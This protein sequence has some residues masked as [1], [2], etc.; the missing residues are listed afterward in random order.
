[1][2]G[3]PRIYFKD[4]REYKIRPVVI[5]GE[6]TALDIDVVI[7]PISTHD[8][9]SKYDIPIEYWKETGLKVASIVRVSKITTIHES[10]TIRKIG[11]MHPSD[12]EKVLDAG[13]RLFKG[14][15]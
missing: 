12:L 9:R 5:V 8:P 2:C 3:S 4:I 1:M 14:W 11:E 7:S 6:E 13:V 10:D 15:N